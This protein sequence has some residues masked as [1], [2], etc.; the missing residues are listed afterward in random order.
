MD[1]SGFYSLQPLYNLCRTSFRMH[2]Q[3]TKTTLTLF[4]IVAALTLIAAVVVNTQAFAQPSDDR[5]GGP[6]DRPNGQCKQLFN[7]NVC[8]KFNTGP[9]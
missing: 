4:A 2:L 6:K 1:E 9:R 3:T 5:Q 8:K 7:E